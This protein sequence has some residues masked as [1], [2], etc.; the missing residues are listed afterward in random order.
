MFNE[1]SPVTKASCRTEFFIL[2]L[3]HCDTGNIHQDVQL[4]SH[5]QQLPQ[6]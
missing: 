5:T 3:D 6:Q 1:G 4:S 2:T